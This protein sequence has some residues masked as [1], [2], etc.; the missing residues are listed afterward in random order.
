M[1]RQSPLKTTNKKMEIEEYINKHKHF[2]GKTRHAKQQSRNLDLTPSVVKLDSDNIHEIPKPLK[3]A[4]VNCI[5]L[6]QK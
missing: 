3:I 1:R 5:P 6:G 2:F 4:K